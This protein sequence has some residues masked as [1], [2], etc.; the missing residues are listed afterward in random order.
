MR[1]AGVAARDWLTTKGQGQSGLT[2][3][4]TKR[5]LRAF[6]RRARGG[7]DAAKVTATIVVFGGRFSEID[8]ARLQ[9]KTKPGPLKVAPKARGGAGILVSPQS[10]LVVFPRGQRQKNAPKT[11]IFYSQDGQR[12]AADVDFDFRDVIRANRRGA[13]VRFRRVLRRE[14]NLA[15]LLRGTR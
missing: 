14:V 4:D 7:G 3:A 10:G 2:R 8:A 13:I 15:G 1:R 6:Y 12:K 5:R 11:R 9:H